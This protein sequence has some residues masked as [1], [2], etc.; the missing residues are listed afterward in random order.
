[1]AIHVQ[2]AD[3]QHGD[4]LHVL[5]VRGEE[6]MNID[7]EHHGAVVLAAALVGNKQLQGANHARGGAGEGHIREG[8]ENRL[9]N[10]GEVI[11][12]EIIGSHFAKTT[13]AGSHASVHG[14]GELG[15]S[16]LLRVC[17][18]VGL[19]GERLEHRLYAFVPIVAEVDA[20]GGI[21][22]ECWIQPV[23]D[24]ALDGVNGKEKVRER[25]WNNT[26]NFNRI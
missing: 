19:L 20:P 23:F 21:R 25:K 10:A 5:A 6:R 26:G 15:R 12:V 24:S 3:V 4:A 17:I 2:Q 1:M 16:E 22:R 18:A 13:T 11:P 9:W 8:G 7:G 14:E